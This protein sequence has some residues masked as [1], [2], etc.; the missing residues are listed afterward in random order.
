VQYFYRLN[1]PSPNSSLK[2][3]VKTYTS[4]TSFAQNT[5]RLHQSNG[6]TT[7]ILQQKHL[8]I[9]LLF[10]VSICSI[11]ARHCNATANVHPI[12]G[13][14]YK[15][16]RQ[17]TSTIEMSNLTNH[18][19]QPVSIHQMAPPQKTSSCSLLLMYWP[20]K[21]ER[22]SWPSWLTC[23]GWLTHITGHEWV[24]PA[25][26]ATTGK[27]HSPRMDV[28]QAKLM[29]KRVKTSIIILVTYFVTRYCTW[30]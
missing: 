9:W 8:C 10:K 19:L 27:V 29:S 15:Q 20:Q 2:S 14:C 23:S 11:K 22:L 17:L 28:L 25:C 6:K 26:A 30:T 7:S 18:G 13:L 16:N 4:N 3:L 21:D 24:F 5:N 12:S 1:A